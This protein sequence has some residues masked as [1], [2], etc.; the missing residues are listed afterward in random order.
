[1]SSKN[2]NYASNNANAEAVAPEAA[3]PAPEAVAP[4]A[5]AP[6][7]DVAALQATVGAMQSSLADAMALIAQQQAE[8]VALRTAPPAPV[9]AMPDMVALVA[10]AQQTASATAVLQ[11]LSAPV[12][13]PGSARHVA[14]QALAQCQGQTKPVVLETLRQAETW[15]H[16]QNGRTVKGIAPA[17][18]LRTFAAH[19]AWGAA[20][21]AP[22][23]VAPE[24]STETVAP[25]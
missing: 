25:E 1:M 22:E 23:T 13:K 4:E 11:V 10:Q 2:R 15:W 3:A 20:A 8:L 5:A 16:Q 24:T 19:I 6:A 18:W 14:W 12:V 7:V 9:V 17:G 21:P